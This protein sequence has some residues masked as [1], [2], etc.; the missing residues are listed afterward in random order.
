MRSREPKL[1]KRGAVKDIWKVFYNQSSSRTNSTLIVASSRIIECKWRRLLRRMGTYWCR[2]FTATGSSYELLE[3][4]DGTK[5]VPTK[6]EIAEKYNGKLGFSYLKS[7]TLWEQ[8]KTD[9]IEATRRQSTE[10]T[11]IVSMPLTG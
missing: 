3:K 10:G 5:E 6:E 11:Q 9:L 2:R 1:L 4:N 7:I 8:Q